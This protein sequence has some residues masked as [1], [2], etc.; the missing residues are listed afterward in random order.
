MGRREEGP[1]DATVHIVDVQLQLV[2]ECVQ[3]RLVE[4]L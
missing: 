3:P 2:N 4:C 1:R